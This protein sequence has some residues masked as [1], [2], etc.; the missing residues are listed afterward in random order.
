MTEA[1][2]R[3]TSI[4]PINLSPLCGFG[5]LNT[6]DILLNP[7]RDRYMYGPVQPQCELSGRVTPEFYHGV[8]V[9][10]ITENL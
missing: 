7:T 1:Q 8:E 2:S 5:D 10:F 9:T 6:S 3:Q 4:S